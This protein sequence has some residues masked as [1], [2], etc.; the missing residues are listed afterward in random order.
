[1]LFNLY[2]ALT[3]CAI[4]NYAMEFSI[5]FGNGLCDVYM[6]DSIIYSLN[7]MPYSVFNELTAVSLFFHFF[8]S[9][10]RCNRSWN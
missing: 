1:M 7:K 5:F 6:P 3:K 8:Y 10:Y 9:L 2:N 4:E